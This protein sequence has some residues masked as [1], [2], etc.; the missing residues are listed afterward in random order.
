MNQPGVRRTHKETGLLEALSEKLGLLCLSDLKY[1]P[2]P[3]RLLDSVS[4]FAASDY[5]KEEWQDAAQYFTGTK[6]AF[7]SADAARRFLIG[8]FTGSESPDSQE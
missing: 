7:L 8:F 1:V 2:S 4:S 6:R 3:A 5:S